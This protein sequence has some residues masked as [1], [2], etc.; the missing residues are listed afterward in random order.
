MGED[1]R[2]K[3]RPAFVPAAAPGSSRSDCCELRRVPPT[4]SACVAAVLRH[5]E[6]ALRLLAAARRANMFSA[7]DPLTVAQLST[8]SSK[9]FQREHFFAAVLDETI[10]WPRVGETR[11]S[12][13]QVSR[14]PGV[15]GSF[16]GRGSPA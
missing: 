4:A 16:G 3:S 9:S 10:N 5:A 8:H 1:F 14:R 7:D 12:Q 6:D 11:T 2:L 13:A 15:L